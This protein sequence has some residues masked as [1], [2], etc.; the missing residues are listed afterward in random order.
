MSLPSFF[1]HLF[2]SESDE[3]TSSDADT[4]T[5]SVGETTTTV[6][7]SALENGGKSRKEGKEG[8]V[9]TRIE[10]GGAGSLSETYIGVVADGSLGLLDKEE[11]E[12]ESERG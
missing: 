9:S 4:D 10:R 2:F 11:G 6:V 12:R 3:L 8:K 7:G 1:L 5:S